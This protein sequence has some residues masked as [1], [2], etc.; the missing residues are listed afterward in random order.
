MFECSYQL[1]FGTSGPDDS[2]QL[3]C[4]PADVELAH[5]RMCERFVVG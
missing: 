2:L 1:S 5:L 3:F 4:G